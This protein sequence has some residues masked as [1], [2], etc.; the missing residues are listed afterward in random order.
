MTQPQNLKGVYKTKKKDGSVYYRASLTFRQKHISL[1]SFDSP[2]K[3]H[4]AYLEG[5]RVLNSQ[6]HPGISDYQPHF[7]LSFE[8]W[9]SLINFRDNGFYFGTPIYV[10]SKYFL[11]YFSED[12]VLKFDIDD[13]FY[14]SS[15]KIM[16]RNGHLFVADY[17]MQVNIMNRYGIKNYARLNVDYRFVNGDETDFRYENIEIINT[18]HGVT[19]LLKHG[20]KYYKCA[21]HINGNYTIGT[22]PTALEAAIAYNK[23]IDILHGKGLTKNFAPNYIEDISPSAYAQI[24]HGLEISEKIKNYFSP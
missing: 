6:D 9:V 16:K 22:Y 3:A 19:P 1:G 10:F 24:Y 4:Q 13:L 20:R 5:I 21:I 8:K 11:Y 23:A 7:S 18:Y 2:F 17:G 14:Y 15:H 12:L